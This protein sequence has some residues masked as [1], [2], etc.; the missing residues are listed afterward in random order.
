MKLQIFFILT[1]RV[2]K[3]YVKIE[4]KWIQ[5]VLYDHR[6]ILALHP[7][8]LIPATEKVIKPRPYRIYR[9]KTG[10]CFWS[11]SY[12]RSKIPFLSSGNKLQI[13]KYPPFEQTLCID[14]YRKKFVYQKMELQGN[15]AYLWKKNYDDS[16]THL[17]FRQESDI[18]ITT[19]LQR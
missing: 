6:S 18:R 5:M 16:G 19:L 14:T 17:D 7:C 8:V 13:F 2:L 3:S 1:I 9:Q 15:I 4:L 12:T 10:N 11:V